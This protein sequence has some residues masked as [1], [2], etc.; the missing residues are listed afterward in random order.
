MQTKVEKLRCHQV[1][2]GLYTHFVEEYER[3]DCAEIYDKLIGKNFYQLDEDGFQEFRRTGGHENKCTRVRGKV[4]SRPTE[5]IVYNKKKFHF[6][7]NT[8]IY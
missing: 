6:K 4:A 8:N 5:T 1:V 2:R 7:K 3:S